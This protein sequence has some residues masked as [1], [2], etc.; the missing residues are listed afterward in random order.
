MDVYNFTS[1]NWSERFATPP[2]MA[3]SHLGVASD[4]RRYVYVVSGQRGPQCTAP[5]VALAF[6]LDTKTRKWESFPSL[7]APRL[8]IACFFSR[9]IDPHLF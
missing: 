2:E 7:P 3:H 5:P 6:V 4:G 1:R 8:D 9:S